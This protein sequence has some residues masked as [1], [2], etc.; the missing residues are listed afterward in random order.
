V[1]V[2][3][4][5]ECFKRT[6]FTNIFLLV[7]LEDFLVLNWNVKSWPKETFGKVIRY[8]VFDL[9]LKF[10]TL[11]LFRFNMLVDIVLMV[12]FVVILRLSKKRLWRPPLAKTLIMIPSFLPF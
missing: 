1:E 9:P 7:S 8:K 10:S 4:K 5:F 3:L 12:K 2:K 11:K 6:L